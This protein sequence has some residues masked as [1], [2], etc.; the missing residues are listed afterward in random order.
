[1]RKSWLT[2]ASVLAAAAVEGRPAEAQNITISPTTM[3]FSNVRVGTTSAAAQTLTVTNNTKLDSGGIP[4]ASSPFSG[5][6][7]TFS[8]TGLNNGKTNTA[9]FMFAPTASGSASQTINVTGTKG[10]TTTTAPLALSGLGVGPVYSSTPA[11]LSTIDFGTL[12]P[13]EMVVEDLKISNSSTD[14]GGPTLTNLTLLTASLSGPGFKLGSFTPGTVLPEGNTFDLMIDFT[15]PT[16]LGPETGDLKITTDQG[17]ALG[18]TG[19]VFDYTL[20][21]NVA[22]APPAT[23]EPASLTLL[24]TALT[25]LGAA[26]GLRRRKTG[27]DAALTGRHT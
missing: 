21:A 6:G 7:V 16:T 2:A 19:A 3:D 22:V 11:P 10:T 14:P 15:A 24:A 13:G 4:A 23:P 20:T 27:D 12:T 17:A 8:G 25:G 26:F 18:T 1:M 5:G 9:S